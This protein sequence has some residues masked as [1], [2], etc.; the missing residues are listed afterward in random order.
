MN[1]TTTLLNLLYSKIPR[2]HTTDN[3]KEIYGLLN[4]YE[5]LLK[6][7]EAENGW[8]EKNTA[9]YFDEIDMVRSLVKRSSDNKASKKNKDQF[10]D[11]ASG[12]FKDSMQSLIAL[13]ADGSRLA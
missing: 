3:V 11:E 5:L 7:I 13:Y 1:A 12:T 6:S 10:F 2:R 8:Y 4:E 9:I